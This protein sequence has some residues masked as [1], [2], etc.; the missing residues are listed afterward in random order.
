[1]HRILAIATLVLTV[2]GPGAVRSSGPLPIFDAHIHYNRTDWA[3]IDPQRVISLWDEAGVR[4]ALVSS[5][6]DDGTLRL[7]DAAPGRVVRFLRPYRTDADRA[8]WFADPEVFAYVEQRLGRSG[9]RGIGEFHLYD[10][11]VVTRHMRRWVVLA[12]EHKL[13]LQVHCSAGIVQALQAME[14]KARILWAH[15]GLDEPPQ[16][17]GATLAGNPG[18]VTELSVRAHDIAPDGKLDP[19]WRALFLRFPDRFMIGTDTSRVSRW[20]AYLRLIGDHR[21]WLE[22]LPRE[23][24]AQI[25]H[26]NAERYFAER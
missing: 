25:A 14:P 8:A 6:P 13:T 18:L 10:L 9:Y 4:R 24:A 17:I 20:E 23:V 26:G 16:A 12:L 1:M 2:L 11:E 22:Q 15:A 5:T 19:Q 7:Y 3:Q 21:R